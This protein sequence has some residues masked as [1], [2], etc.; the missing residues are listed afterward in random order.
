[1]S[2]I[3]TVIP[4]GSKDKRP[5]YYQSYAAKEAARHFNEGFR[6]VLIKGPTG[7]GKTLMSKLIGLSTEVRDALDLTHGKIRI[8]FLVNKNRL[9]RQALAEYASVSD[10][11]ELI[12]Q[13]AFS[14]IPKD[15]IEKG[16]DITFMDECHHEA[17]MSIQ[18]Q[19]PDLIKKPIV[20]FT[21]NDDRGDGLLLKFDRVVTAITKLQAAREGFIER[22]AINTIIDTGKNDKTELA[23]DT[24][25]EYHD[26]VGNAIVFVRTQAEA[27]AV[28]R[29]L[30]Y[31]MK[32]KCALLDST[33]N[34]AD[35][36]ASLEK[37]SNREIQFIVNCQR[38]GEGIDTPN[39]T[40]VMMFRDFH[41]PAEKEQYCGRASRPDSPFNIWESVNPLKDGVVA[42]DCVAYPR[43]ERLIYKKAGQWNERIIS[44]HDEYWG[45]MNTYRF[46]NLRALTKLGK[47]EGLVFEL[48]AN[49]D[50]LVAGITTKIKHKDPIESGRAEL[51]NT[52]TDQHRAPSA[53]P[54][55]GASLSM[56]NAAID[57]ASDFDID[58]IQEVPLIA[59][60]KAEPA[61]DKE[62][63]EKA[64][65]PESSED[66]FQF[67][68]F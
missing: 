65:Q 14:A 20:G 21:A 31:T 39:V 16:W 33:S 8:L 64:K 56:S 44:G 43:C 68:L 41:S 37:L 47:E 17:M 19:L 32:K 12:P 5:R 53:R 58:D 62:P 29:H 4:F 6:R 45:K 34:E 57:H 24:L 3:T 51:S 26:K 1:M 48:P 54:A 27:R 66:P 13:S 67:G 7:C 18:H 15:V 42:S 30:R 9:S 22:P 60:K 63:V 28:Y 2:D 59:A 55:L 52:E 10:A 46:G 11:I 36:D 40:D 35:L 50:D 61:S 23:I 25:N 38:I 49:I